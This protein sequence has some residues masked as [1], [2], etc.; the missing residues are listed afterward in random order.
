[1]LHLFVY[2]FVCCVDLFVFYFL[3]DAM[4]VNQLSKVTLFWQ[5]FLVNGFK[6]R[7]QLNN[8]TTDWKSVI[9]I[10]SLKAELWRRN[11]KVYESLCRHVGRRLPLQNIDSFHFKAC[12][13]LNLIPWIDVLPKNAKFPNIISKD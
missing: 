2:H 8:E 10:K 11:T 3:L 6:K 1:M 4:K 13:L 5:V 9:G 7:I 12:V